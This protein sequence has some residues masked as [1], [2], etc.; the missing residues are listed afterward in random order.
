MPAFLAVMV[1]I[2]WVA[3]KQQSQQVAQGM[4]QI[5]QRTWGIT[6]LQDR[7]HFTKDQHNPLERFL[8]QGSVIVV[9]C[10][11]MLIDGSLLAQE[12]G[13]VDAPGIRRRSPVGT[14]YPRR[15]QQGLAGGKAASYSADFVPA[16]AAHADD[17][18][19]LSG[20]FFPMAIVADSPGV[21]S[22]ADAVE[23]SLQRALSCRSS[24]EEG[25]S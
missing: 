20:T 17:K 4:P 15:D 7:M 24:K 13:P 14:R 19:M 21:V 12:M 9:V 23:R 11:E 6:A 2:G 16:F 18:N 8:A 25:I 10:Q 22:H 3:E 1:R 5:I